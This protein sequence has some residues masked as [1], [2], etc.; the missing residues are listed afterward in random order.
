MPQ[1]QPDQ[2]TFGDAAG[3]GNWETGHY[4][5]HV[6]FVEA[7][8]QQTPSVA[9][10]NYPLLAFLTAGNA[11]SVMLESHMEAHKALRAAIGIT[12]VELAQVNLDDQGQFYQWFGDHATEHAQIRQ[13]LGIV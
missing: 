12:G 4:R 13:V 6:Q 5:E 1:F 10:T 9:I 7:L 11:R 2:V 8:A 3:Y